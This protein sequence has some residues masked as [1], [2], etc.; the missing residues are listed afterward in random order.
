MKNPGFVFRLCRSQPVRLWVSHLTPW[1]LNVFVSK[2]GIITHT[3]PAFAKI[4]G[5]G[6]CE[7]L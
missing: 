6:I 3:S 4:K 1:S 5:D 2:V 7:S